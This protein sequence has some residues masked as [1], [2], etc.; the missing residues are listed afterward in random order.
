MLFGRKQGS[1][2]KPVK[3]KKREER[4]ASFHY[5]AANFCPYF[6]T[7]PSAPHSLKIFIA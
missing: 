5:S 7:H 6:L 1:K 2:A 3:H 4:D